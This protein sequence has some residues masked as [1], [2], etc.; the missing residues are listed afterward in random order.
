MGNI[1]RKPRHAE[2]LSRLDTLSPE[3]ERKWG[4]M[5]PHQA[6]C[7]LSDSFKAILHDRPLNPHPPDFRRRVMRF[8][9]FTSPVPWPKGVPT[10]ARVDAEKGGTPPGDFQADV[11]GLKELLRRYVESDGKTLEPHYIWGDMSRGEWGRY[12]YRH[13]DHHLRQFGV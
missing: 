6:V 1:F 2:L 5:T 3:S 12:G 9:A 10:S 4:R 13:V 7:H 8:V 11:T